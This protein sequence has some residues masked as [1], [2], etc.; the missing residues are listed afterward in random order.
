M[1]ADVAIGSWLTETSS[2]V[3]L[4]VWSAAP[5]PGCYWCHMPATDKPDAPDRMVKVR[6]RKVRGSAVPLVSIV[7]DA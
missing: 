2:G 7:E 4:R 5:G 1:T 3:K 6:V